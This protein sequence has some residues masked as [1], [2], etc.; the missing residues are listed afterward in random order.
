MAVFI[1]GEEWWKWEVAVALG[2][3]E[4]MRTLYFL[5]CCLGHLEEVV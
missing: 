4:D 1:K 3:R 2:F 5:V